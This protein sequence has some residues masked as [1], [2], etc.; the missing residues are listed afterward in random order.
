MSPRRDPQTGQFVSGG[1]V[2]F[3]ELDVVTGS[4]AS[5]IPAADLSG[6]TGSEVTFG[7]QTIA[8][9][10]TP[11]LDRNEVFQVERLEAVATL[12]LPT[13]AT[14]ESSGEVEWAVRSDIGEGEIAAGK[15]FYN[16]FV[17]REDGI[18]DINQHQT[19]EADDLLVAGRLTGESSL[20]DTVN[21]AGA[22]GIHGHERAGVVYDGAGPRYDENDALSIPHSF[23]FDAISD[24]A[25]TASFDLMLWGQVDRSNC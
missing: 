8:V 21:G 4:L 14:A 3:S 13:S 18:I 12:T 5:T 24:H 11:V 20:L 9:D 17:A 25:I 6:T 15:S 16:S 19:D 10:F 22:G 1:S 2:P 23:S 7:E